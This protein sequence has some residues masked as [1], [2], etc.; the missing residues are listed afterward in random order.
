MGKEHKFTQGRLLLSNPQAGSLL[1]SDF[2][3]ENEGHL[4][5]GNKVIQVTGQ[6]IELTVA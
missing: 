6:N 3:L 4:K 5:T 2:L 1:A